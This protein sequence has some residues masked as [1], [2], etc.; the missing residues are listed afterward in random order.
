MDISNSNESIFDIEQEIRVFS[1]LK[2]RII[3]EFIKACIWSN[4]YLRLELSICIRSCIKNRRSRLRFCQTYCRFGCC[5]S[6]TSDFRNLLL[7]LRLKQIDICSNLFGC[8]HLLTGKGPLS[9]D[10]CFGESILSFSEK[11]N[12]QNL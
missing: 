9:N 2:L 4:F 11:I 7:C 6:L 3:N 8:F 1:R 5:F 10:L 12:T